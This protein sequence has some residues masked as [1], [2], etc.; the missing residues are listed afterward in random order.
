MGSSHQIAWRDLASYGRLALRRTDRYI[1]LNTSRSL[2]NAAS[3]RHQLFVTLSLAVAVQGATAQTVDASILGSVRDSAGLALPNSR[4]VARNIATGVEW[5]VTATS[6]GRFAFLQLPLGGPYTLTVRRVGFR[7]ASRSGY[8][9]A[10]GTRVVVDIVL[11]RA[12]AELAPVVVAGT[13][14]ERRAPS[15]GANFRVSGEQLAAVPAV[16]RN[17]TDLTALS[18]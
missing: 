17:F 12:V 18:P 16:N 1:R 9:L 6:T 7:A 13:T 11:A 10:L 14:D 4:V 5:T 2:R 8:E 3:V 15:M